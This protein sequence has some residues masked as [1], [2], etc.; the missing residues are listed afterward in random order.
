[1]VSRLPNLLEAVEFED[2]KQA[3]RDTVSDVEKQIAR[4]EVIYTLLDCHMSSSYP[5]F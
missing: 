1:M 5:S 4:M 3:I 2:M